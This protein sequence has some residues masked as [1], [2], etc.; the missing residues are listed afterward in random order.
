MERNVPNIILLG[1]VGCLIRE[2]LEEESYKL[3]LFDAKDMDDVVNIAMS[4]TKAGGI[5]LLS[6]AAS[7]YDIF[8]NFED[9]GDQ[10]KEKVRE[11]SR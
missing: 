6:P 4:K 7:S 1:E 3:P 5:C 10:Y 2:L 11:Y 8:H 9:R